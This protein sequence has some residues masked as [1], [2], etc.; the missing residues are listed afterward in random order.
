MIRI[1]EGK[2]R[3]KEAGDRSGQLQQRQNIGELL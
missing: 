3:R 2:E 1:K